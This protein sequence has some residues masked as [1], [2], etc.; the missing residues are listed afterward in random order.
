MAKKEITIEDLA[1]MVQKG[2]AQ[3]A[4]K[5]ELRELATKAEL[6]DLRK[7]MLEH[8]GLLEDDIRDLKTVAGPLVRI[9]AALEYDMRNLNIRVNRIERK[10]GLAK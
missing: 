7:D 5:A 6:Q 2:F 9:V 3:T 1:L 10:V 8:F 4:T